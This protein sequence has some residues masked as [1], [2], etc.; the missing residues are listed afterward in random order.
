MGRYFLCA[1]LLAVIGVLLVTGLVS[2]GLLLTVGG[3]DPTAA[4]PVGL[5]LYLL[6]AVVAY[7]VLRRPG[8]GE[9]QL[10]PDED[11]E[12]DG[13]EVARREAERTSGF[14]E[15]TRVRAR[16]R[17]GQDL[18]SAEQQV[19]DDLADACT[20]RA[21]S[22]GAAGRVAS[23]LVLV[24]GALLVY[25][26]NLKDANAVLGAVATLAV[27]VAVLVSER[28]LAR[29]IRRDLLATGGAPTPGP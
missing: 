5:L 29:R 24:F 18:S 22:A 28:S 6:A 7:A 14:A 20:R 11:G 23:V 12:G 15:I 25:G 4:V 17:S 10:T 13:G 8:R 3:L 16:M 1:D 27:V 9:A 21:A 26:L 19:A 2:F